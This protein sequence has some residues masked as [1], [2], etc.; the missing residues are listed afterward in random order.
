MV[1]N[2][3]GSGLIKFQ[4]RITKRAVPITTT[5]IATT[6]LPIRLISYSISGR[7]IASGDDA[8]LVLLVTTNSAIGIV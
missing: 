7:P 1:P 2:S 4:E 3:V 6:I 5:A 8:F